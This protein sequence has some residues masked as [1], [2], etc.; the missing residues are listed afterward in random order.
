MLVALLLFSQSFL[1]RQLVQVAHLVRDLDERRLNEAERSI[2]TQLAFWQD[3]DP[4]EPSIVSRLVNPAY[5]ERQCPLWF[6]TED[7]VSVP[8]AAPVNQINALFDGW[9]IKCVGCLFLSS[10]Y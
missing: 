9:H 7:G 10:W 8:K 5:W 1:T 3:G 6:P 2:S 4:T